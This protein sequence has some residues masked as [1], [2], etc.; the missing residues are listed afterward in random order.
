MLV[1]AV[2]DHVPPVFGVRS[3][4]EVLGN[5]SA[6]RSFKETM[7]RLEEAARKIA[8]SHLH[9]HIRRREVLP[10]AQQVNFSPELDV[11]LGEVV[12]QLS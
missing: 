7:A 1:R 4:T 8:D 6:G 5:H 9:T 10:T 12:R 3:F 2:M 11:L